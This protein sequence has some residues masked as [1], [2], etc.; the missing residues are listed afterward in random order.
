MTVY[1]WRYESASK[2]RESWKSTRKCR[3]FEKG[4]DYIS[5]TLE[6][7]NRIN[8]FSKKTHN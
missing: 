3:L 5:E 7:G 4:I 1:V 8:L 2:K 6:E